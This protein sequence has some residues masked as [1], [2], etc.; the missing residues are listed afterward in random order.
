M[1]DPIRSIRNLG[2]A[3]EAACHAA[4]I[5]DAE[6][7]RALGADAA[8][9]Q[10]IAHGHRPHVLAFS[11]L[12]LGLQGRHWNDADPREKAALRARFDAAKAAAARSVP[13]D[14]GR[15]PMDAALDEIGVIVRAAQPTSSRPEKK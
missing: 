6:T 1:T 13:H 5:M 12:A 2:A 10:M 8:Y 11:A 9:A 7:L 3:M 15:T 14:K 4:G